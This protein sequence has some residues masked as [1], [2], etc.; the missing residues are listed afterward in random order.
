M[1]DR[2]SSALLFAVVWLLATTST[3]AQS[4]P[5][6]HLRGTRSLD[7]EGDIAS[8][9][10]AGVD[11]FLLREL[12]RSIGRRAAYWNRDLSSPDAYQESI[13]PNRERLAHIL[14]VRDP[15]VDRPE[16]SLQASVSK[17]A[18]VGRG[19]TYEVFAVTWPAFA[20]V[21][22]QG[23]LL[24]PVGTTPVATVIAIPDCGVLP[25]QLAGLLPGVEPESQY[26]RRLAEN[27]CRVIVP[28]LINR[29]ERMSKL[30][31]REWI[32]RSAFELGRG[33]I[34]YE[35]QKVLAL[36]DWVVREQGDAARVGVIG[37]G[38]GGLLSLYAAALD[39]RID[40][41]CVSGYFSPRESLWQE[42]LDRNVF[43][44]PGASRRNHLPHPRSARIRS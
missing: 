11:R 5:T 2:S 40:V 24:V 14:G 38:E 27:G 4:T 3:T 16:P 33:L 34:G 1:G 26:A 6:A 30:T 19:G 42:P 28:L 31:N 43:G 44:R 10:V 41:A 9:L 21:T 13:K 8:E 12:E 15:R 36:V 29:E 35:V 25:E 18:R 20:D 37:W 23:L 22:G 17:P 39:P 7:M 32:Y